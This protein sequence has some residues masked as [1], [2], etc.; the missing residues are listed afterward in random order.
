METESGGFLGLFGTSTSIHELD[1]ELDTRPTTIDA[2][3]DL[4]IDAATGDLTL[5]AVQLDSAGDILLSAEQGTVALLSN[6]DLSSEQEY[7]HDQ[8]GCGSPRR[9]RGTTKRASST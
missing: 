7:E 6:T 1:A 5:D 2:G 3:G 4:T 8:G 9:T